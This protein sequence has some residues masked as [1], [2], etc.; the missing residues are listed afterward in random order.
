MR[1]L[2]VPHEVVTLEYD[3][4]VE[5]KETPG[6]AR[7]LSANPLAQFPTLITPEGAVMTEMVAIV[8]CEYLY[9]P[10]HIYLHHSGFRSK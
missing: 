10:F 8:L 9:T 2:G 4:V 6:L 5:R 1:L 7:L 3:K